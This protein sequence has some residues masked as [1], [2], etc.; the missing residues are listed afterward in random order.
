[1]VRVLKKIIQGIEYA[2][3]GF[4]YAFREDEHFRI[5]A[6]LG[7]SMAI[8]SLILLEPPISVVVALV[9]YSVFVL[10][11]VNTAIE[12]AVD[13]A[14]REF[15]PDAKAAKDV[16]AAAV[17]SVGLFAAA[18]DIMFVLPKILAFLGF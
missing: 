10:E 9:N 2:I 8:V 18:V 11:L 4:I 3:E 12:K 16:S 7:V 5:N 6:F 17:F 13:T 15:S 1:M 14:T